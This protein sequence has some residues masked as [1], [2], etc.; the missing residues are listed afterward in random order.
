MIELFN[1]ADRSRF[2]WSGNAAA[3]AQDRANPWKLLQHPS[4]SGEPINVV[5]DKNTAMYSLH[6]YG[7]VGEEFELDYGDGK[8]IQ[9]RIVGLLANSILQ[10]SLIVSEA[11]LLERFPEVNGYRYFFDRYTHR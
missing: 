7:G 6:L 8:K 2:A 1:E 9:F 10:G 11:D 3:S 5:L 4:R